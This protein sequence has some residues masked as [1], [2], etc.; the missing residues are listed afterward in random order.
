MTTA[1]TSLLG[2]ALPVSGELSGTWGTTVNDNITQYLDAAVAGTNT[3]SSDSDVTLVKTTNASLTG[4]SSQ[5]AVLLWTAGGTA[6]RTII[7]PSASSGGRQFYI[8]VNKTSSTQSIKLC[9]AGPTTGVT[10][11]A[12]N[13]AICAWNG[14]DFIQVAG[15]VNLTT[16]VTGT[17]PVA[18]G[19]TSSATLT[20]NNVLLGNGT[21]AL[22]VVAPGTVGNVLT[23][24]GTTWTSA[25]AMPVGSFLWHTASSV[26]T[27]YLE[28]NGAAISR[29]TYAALF[30]VIG[31][32][33][34]VGD[35]T[36]TF[37]VPDV[38][39]YF[40]RGYDN[41]RG[42][43]SGRAFGSNQ[44]ATHVGTIQDSR[45]TQQLS[46]QTEGDAITTSPETFYI[47]SGYQNTTSTTTGGVF[48]GSRPINIAFLPCIRYQ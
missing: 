3:F 23:S 47:M 37:N 46:A 39:G 29:S 8:V 13:S 21:S 35:G 30:A 15:L 2:L 6:T 32:T 36:T 41:G 38:R 1:Y 24:N 16:N 25:A 5:Y 42:V 40:I 33:Y 48:V 4:T 12:N 26:P 44:V 28:A 43:D 27:S 10:I 11:T 20:A 31:T 19:G 17:L 45:T 18:N 22:Q 34:G 14:S 7:A 9:G